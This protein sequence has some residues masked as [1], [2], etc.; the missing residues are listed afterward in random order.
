MTNAALVKVVNHLLAGEMLTETQLR[1]HLDSVIDDINAAL[2]STFP[3]FTDVSEK[4][5]L[6][7]YVFF[8]DIYL[9]TVVAFGAAH[10]FY[11]TDEEGA[12]SALGYAQKYK[13]KLF[14]MVRDYL[15]AVP[16]IFQACAE[17]AIIHP[18]DVD[19]SYAGLG[20]ERI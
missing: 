16:V 6:T 13:Q 11:L 3:T 1:P 4:Y 2:N 18:N 12:P 15:H 7:E 17:N 9:R 20:I 14:E 19:S 10:Y 8:P 5:G